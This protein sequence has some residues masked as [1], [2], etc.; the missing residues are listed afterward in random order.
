MLL[1][2]A[3]PFPNKRRTELHWHFVMGGDVGRCTVGGVEAREPQLVGYAL[4]EKR[5]LL[6]LTVHQHHVGRL[7]LLDAGFGV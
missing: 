4:L 6:P 2:R 7:H 3:P 5:H 1:L